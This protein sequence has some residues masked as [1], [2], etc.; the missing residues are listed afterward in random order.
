[1]NQAGEE[2]SF[3]SYG[4]TVV[5][6]ANGFEVESY[7]PGGSKLKMSGTSMASPNVANLAAKLFALDAALTPAQ[8]IAL[9]KQG[10]TASPDGRRHLVDPK[11]TVALLQSTKLPK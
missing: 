4:D 6:H 2:T 9:I 7:I 1:V 8:A 5:V 11:R 3:T 10:A